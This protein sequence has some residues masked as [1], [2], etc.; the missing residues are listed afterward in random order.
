MGIREQADTHSDKGIIN[1]YIFYIYYIDI[2]LFFTF[3]TFSRTEA[4]SQHEAGKYYKT[5]IN[6]ISI[7]IK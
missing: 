1:P 4:A 7:L 5:G 3:F 6:L 2:Q